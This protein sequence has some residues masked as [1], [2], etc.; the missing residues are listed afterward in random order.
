MIS[1][2]KDLG[3]TSVELMPVQEWVRDKWLIEKGL[4][5]YWGYNPISYFSP[6]C[7]Y[8][9]SDCT[10]GQVREFKEMVK[11]LH[12]NGIEILIDVV[13]NHTGE[14]NHLGPTLSF[15]G[16]DNSSYYLL[17]PENPRF[18]I[19]FTGT[20]NTLNLSHPRVLQMVLD[21]LRYWV[22]EMHV[23]GFRFDLAPALAR[24]LF[25]VNMLSTFFIAIQQDPILSKVKLIAEPWDLGEGGYQVG[26]FPYQWAEW[27]DKYRDTIRKF[28]RGEAIIYRELAYRL[29][30]SPD[31]YQSSGRTPFASI[32]YVTSHDGFTLEDLVSYNYKHNEGNYLN[33]EDGP[34]EN[35]SWNCGHEGET[36]NPEVVACREKQKRNYVIT[37]LI[38][39]GVPMILGGD[40]ISRTQKGNNN[41]FCQDNE[42]S[43]YNWDLNERKEKFR[44]FVKFTIYLR[45]AH[46]VFRRRKFFQGR[47]L[48]GSIFKDV[49]WLSPEGEIDENVWNSL[50]KSIAFILSGD[51]MDEVNDKGER[52]ADFTFLIILNA[53]ER[54]VKFK[55]PNMGSQWELVTWSLLREPSEAEKHVS[56]GQEIEVEPKSSLI[57]LR[58]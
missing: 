39:Q 9:S 44:E 6:D 47:N 1:Y 18:Y 8:S 14:G 38:S 41:A 35:F 52:I 24:E 43:W 55:I 10:G 51:S 36:E 46:P 31:L 22:L 33:N 26:N 37:L 50:T 34:K 42:V 2:F 48:Y 58:N 5:N 15:R 11:E 17:N 25:S 57:F 30:G 56:S 45:K 53:S 54:P 21:S 20:G 29:M 49:T 3:I 16:I 28:W 19:D 12:I 23:D 13:Y 27:N 40:E 7:S 4:T 32:N